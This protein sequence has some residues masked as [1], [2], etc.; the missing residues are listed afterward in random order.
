LLLASDIILCGNRL[1]PTAKSIVGEKFTPTAAAVRV[2][3][4]AGN[5]VRLTGN[6]PLIA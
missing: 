4:M 5:A 6:E 2:L 3:R 1:L